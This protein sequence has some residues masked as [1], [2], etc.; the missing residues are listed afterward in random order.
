MGA[1]SATKRVRIA[2][3]FEVCHEEWEKVTVRPDFFRRSD[4]AVDFEPSVGA[5]KST[6]RVR[7]LIQVSERARTCDGPRLSGKAVGPLTSV[8]G[9]AASQ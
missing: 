1:R 3:A 7:P 9:Y 2:G 8:H 5:L 4:H 6:A